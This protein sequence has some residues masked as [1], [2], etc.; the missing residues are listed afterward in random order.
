VRVFGQ[1][2]FTTSVLFVLAGCAAPYLEEIQGPAL[3]Q[4][5]GEQKISARVKL[6]FPEGINARQLVITAPLRTLRFNEGRMLYISSNE[7]A[8]YIFPVAT[9]L[10]PPEQTDLILHIDGNTTGAAS[11]VTLTTFSTNNRLIAVYRGHGEVLPW[12]GV[13]DGFISNAYSLALKQAL[14]ELIADRAKYENLGD[15]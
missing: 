12:G 8:A 4:L 10:L 2:I 1:T 11:D 6:T 15:E 7:I 13:N 5:V 9:D 14:E 3:R